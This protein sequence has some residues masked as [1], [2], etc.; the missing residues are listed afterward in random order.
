MTLRQLFVFGVLS[1][2]LVVFWIFLGSTFLAWLVFF[3]LVLA[4]CL[5]SYNAKV[6]RLHSSKAI[7]VQPCLCFALSL[8]FALFWFYSVVF[9]VFI[10]KPCGCGSLFLC[11]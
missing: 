5:G 10:Y 11:I 7:L 8:F 9:I 1:L 6:L 3:G 2:V 4:C